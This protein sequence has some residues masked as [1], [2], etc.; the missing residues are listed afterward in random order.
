MSPGGRAAG[1]PAR[2]RRSLEAVARWALVVGVL[3][4]LTEAALA[5]ARWGARHGLALWWLG[6]VAALAVAG[7]AGRLLWPHLA[8][9]WQRWPLPRWS[10]PALVFVVAWGAALVPALTVDTAPFSDFADVYQG[11]QQVA[12]G[13]LDLEQLPYFS[14]WP[15]QSPFALYEGLVLWLSGGSKVPLLVIGATAM[16]GTN[17]LVFLLARRLAGSSAAGL[18]CAFTFMAYPSQYLAAS[19]LTNDHLAT[20]LA[21]LGLYLALRLGWVAPG[22]RWRGLAWALLAGLVLALGNLMR[23]LGPVFLG[24]ALVGLVYGGLRLAKVAGWRDARW[25]VLGLRAIAFTA[26]YLAVGWAASGAIAAAGINY[27]HGT[28]STLPEW[29]FLIALTGNYT[30]GF[31]LLQGPDGRW[32][33]DANEKAARAIR[34]QVK[35]LLDNG[36]WPGHLA[37]QADRL[38][39]RPDSAELTYPA[40]AAGQ[41]ALTAA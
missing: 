24:A 5:S 13:N 4:A 26:C 1:G 29:K 10:L 15:Y 33:P 11:A 27:S 39:G 28:A 30:A 25:R 20:C 18:A 36:T 40:E 7:A 9:W 17:L 31:E 21:Y 41:R 16:A 3:V 12:A 19:Q 37:A 8:A 2:P 14:L 34:H 38:W 6:A 35:T 22:R 23:P 32:L